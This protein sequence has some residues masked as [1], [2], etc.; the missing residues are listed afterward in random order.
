VNDIH[1]IIKILPKRYTAIW[2]AMLIAAF[3]IS[4]HHKA[5]TALHHSN[6]NINYPALLG[7]LQGTWISYEYIL[8]LAKT[9]SPYHSAALMEG[10]FSFTIDSNRLTDDTLHCIA[11]VNGHEDRGLW[12]D[13]TAADSAGGYS[14]GIHKTIDH[15]NDSHNVP[16][17]NITRIKIDSP[18]LTIYTSTFDSVRY[19]LYMPTLRGMAAD[20]PIRHYTTAFL[21]HGAYYTTDSDIVF[22]SSHIYFDTL[23]VG[24]IY[25][26][27]L[28][29]SFDI[30]TDVLSVSDSADYMELFDTKKQNES[31]SYMYQIKKNVLR[32]FQDAD[33]TPCVLYRVQS[34]DTLKR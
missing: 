9:R 22:A 29:D 21:F 15:D 31:R 5:E 2:V 23:H 14:I 7:R 30:N 19:V 34:R 16:N 25:G 13:L 10:I 11:W 20:Y 1:P 12:I 8:N 27:Q 3:G 6:P 28:Y 4:C 24:R 26:S 33:S 18:Y 17:D 32:I